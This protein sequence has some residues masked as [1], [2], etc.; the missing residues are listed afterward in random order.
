MTNPM[1]SNLDL[2]GLQNRLR[3]DLYYSGVEILLQIQCVIKGDSLIVLIEHPEPALPHEKQIFR[4]L[5][6]SLA[7][8]QL[9]EQFK[10]LLYLRLYGKQYPYAFHTYEKPEESPIAEVAPDLPPEEVPFVAENQLTEEETAFTE[11][12]VVESFES[13]EES[14]VWDTAEEQAETAETISR[15]ETEE[16]TPTSRNLLPWVIGGVSL[17]LSFAIIIVYALTRPCVLGECSLIGEAQTLANSSKNILKPVKS[18]RELKQAETDLGKAIQLLRTVPRWSRYYGDV[19]PQLQSYVVRE[20]ALKDLNEGLAMALKT[21]QK[22]QKPPLPLDQWQSIQNEWKAI[23]SR[24]ESVP[25]E[26][27]YYGFSQTKVRLYKETLKTINRFLNQEK[28]AI[29]NL[30]T[31]QEMSKKARTLAGTAQSYEDWTETYTA[32]KTAVDKVKKIHPKTT[33][34]QESRKLLADYT[35]DMVAAR[36]RRSQELFAKQTY[37]EA[38]D[39]GKLAQK[40]QQEKQ[41]SI[42]V[43]R[44]RN[45]VNALKQVP[46]NSFVYEKAQ[47][48]L[49][50]YNQK[51]KSAQKQLKGTV[52]I[53]KAKAD[54]EKTC[55][56]TPRI[57][58]YSIDSNT[59][60][61]YLTSDYIET[62]RETA[63]KA[64]AENNTLTNKQLMV[65]LDSLETALKVISRNT[66]LPVQVFHPNGEL[67]KTY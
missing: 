8:E 65:H 31:A 3:E 58:T 64:K 39:L 50:D 36:D 15:N 1:T 11:P 59:I 9:T 49:S 55:K 41:W 44:W 27:E 40:A 18:G 26:S 53:Q 35:P 33:V 24:F 52:A 37:Q 20:K 61:V 13:T 10:L 30:A 28:Q 43:S 42:A 38:L 34:Y 25:P 56:G 45:A 57:C 17:G 16:F 6:N 2:H 4:V 54:L 48:A 22:S 66:G 5:I 7:E 67:L 51:L 32:W 47:E 46:K 60:K 14:R 19:Q 29:A 23:I 63:L 21:T 62:I 12:P